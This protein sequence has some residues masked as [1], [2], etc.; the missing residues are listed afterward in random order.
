MLPV[1]SPFLNIFVLLTGCCRFI[2]GVRSVCWLFPCSMP[3]SFP[4]WSS[5]ICADPAP[6]QEDFMHLQRRNSRLIC[7]IISCSLTSSD[8]VSQKHELSVL[9]RLCDWLYCSRLFWKHLHSGLQV[10]LL[11]SVSSVHENLHDFPEVLHVKLS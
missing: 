3:S 8:H 10:D 4:L 6:V 5:V 2:A 7:W 9:N 11:V 1:I